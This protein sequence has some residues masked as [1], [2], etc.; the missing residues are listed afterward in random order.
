[1]KRRPIRRY[2]LSFHLRQ[3][4]GTM[5]MRFFV[6]ASTQSVLFLRTGNMSA[7]TPPRS[8]TQTSRSM[9][10]GAI[11]TGN[12]FSGKERMS[13]I[14]GLPTRTSVKFQ[15]FPP[16]CALTQINRPSDGQGLFLARLGRARASPPTSTF[17]GI[18]DLVVLATSLSES[19]ST[20][21][22]AEGDRRLNLGQYATRLFSDRIDWS[23]NNSIGFFDPG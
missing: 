9:S 18:P 13:T 23:P 10:G 16:Y 21:T 11:D 6:L 17:W 22:Y 5:S 19:D 4:V 20:R 1:M 15:T 8:M 7:W 3:C 2:R 12:H 14:T